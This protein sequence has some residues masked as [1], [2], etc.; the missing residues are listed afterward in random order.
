MVFYI[1]T[2]CYVL[3]YQPGSQGKNGVTRRAFCFLVPFS[4]PAGLGLSCLSREC[5]RSPF[6]SLFAFHLYCTVACLTFLQHPSFSSLNHDKAR[7]TTIVHA[8]YLFIYFLRRAL[9]S[10][11]AFLSNGV[12]TRLLKVL[13]RSVASIRFIFQL[14]LRVPTSLSLDFESFQ[15]KQG[16]LCSFSCTDANPPTFWASEGLW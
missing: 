4:P 14:T 8:A 5:L 1:H 10:R 15:V 6:P 11:K 9:E 2:P 16:A 7:A 12:F 3:A 13:A